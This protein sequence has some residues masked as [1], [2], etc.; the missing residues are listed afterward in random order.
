MARPL[1]IELEGAAYHVTAR[2]NERRT[3]FR[4]DGDRS[5]FLETLGQACE[6]FGLVIHAY[7]LMPNHYHLLCATPWANLSRAVGWVQAAYAI[8][9]NRRPGHIHRQ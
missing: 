8:R 5:R 2:G 6:R 9:H 4:D 1:R 7:C 3:I